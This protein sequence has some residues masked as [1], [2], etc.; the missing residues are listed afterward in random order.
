[1]RRSF[2]KHLLPKYP[3]AKTQ[4]PQK[5]K[6]IKR[7]DPRRCH[8]LSILLHDY[9]DQVGDRFSLPELARLCGV[10]QGTA[11]K[12]FYGYLPSRLLYWNI[13][14]YFERHLNLKAEII[15]YDIENTIAEWRQNR[16]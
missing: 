10:A 3:P 8:E 11:K 6:K 5:P 9:R 13:A 7:E 12:W 16:W 2:N 15:K 14:R 1:M 4:T